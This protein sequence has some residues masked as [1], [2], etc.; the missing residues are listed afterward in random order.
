MDPGRA[1]DRHSPNAHL[2]AEAGLAVRHTDP[3]SFPF[4]FKRV[5]VIFGETLPDVDSAGYQPE[6]PIIEVLTDIGAIV[7]PESWSM[8]HARNSSANFF[9]VVFQS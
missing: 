4:K 5:T 3:A 2:L 6:Q 9:V 1:A 8:N 7:E